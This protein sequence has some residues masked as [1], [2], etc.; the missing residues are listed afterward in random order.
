MLGT[1][2]NVIAVTIGSITGILLGKK[3][4][5]EMRTITMHS[6]VLVTLILGMSMALQSMEGGLGAT[7]FLVLIF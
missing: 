1:I 7:D 2:T 3:Y 6:L 4:T 5:D